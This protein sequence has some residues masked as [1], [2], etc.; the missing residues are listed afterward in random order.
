MKGEHVLVHEHAPERPDVY[1]PGRG[2][3][4]AGQ[5]SVVLSVDSS[6]RAGRSRRRLLPVLQDRAERAVGDVPTFEPGEVHDRPR[7]CLSDVPLADAPG[8]CE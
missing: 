2:L 4:P 5:G 3:D 1:C 6:S 7:D 8:F